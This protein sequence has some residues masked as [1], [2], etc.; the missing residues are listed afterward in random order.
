MLGKL[1]VTPGLGAS[2]N[3]YHEPYIYKKWRDKGKFQTPALKNM[4]T[5]RKKKERRGSWM[6]YKV[7]KPNRHDAT[8]ALC[9]NLN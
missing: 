4:L 8:S 3:I 2:L 9:F 6:P 1:V 5:K 7:T